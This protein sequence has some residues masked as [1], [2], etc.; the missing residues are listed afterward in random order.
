L[1]KKNKIKAQSKLP[2]SMK[3]ENPKPV[4]AINPPKKSGGNPEVIGTAPQD[5]E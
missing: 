5:P 1:D 2:K 3:G 4:I